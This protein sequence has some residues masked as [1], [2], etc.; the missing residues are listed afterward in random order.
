MAGYDSTLEYLDG[1]GLYEWLHKMMGFD[2][3]YELK[4]L[5]PNVERRLR[6]WKNGRPAQ[7]D[8][9]DRI[10]CVLGSHISLIPDE[11]W[12]ER[13]KQK[14][15]THVS[16]AERIKAV[17]RVRNGERQCDVAES[18]G[19]RPRTVSNWVRIFDAEG[20]RSERIA[21]R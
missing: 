7:I 21:S 12:I 10:M 16:E 17:E 18:L 8:A 5:K 14:E 4:C 3:M 11:L 1:P 13:P 2:V 9:V 20:H 6:E 19:V 15:P